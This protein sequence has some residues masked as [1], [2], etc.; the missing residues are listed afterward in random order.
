MARTGDDDGKY[1]HEHVRPH[2]RGS[3]RLEISL[4]ESSDL[5]YTPV[6]S[7]VLTTNLAERALNFDCVDTDRYELNF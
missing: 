2:I 3:I 6:L 5:E 4:V 1:I 7:E